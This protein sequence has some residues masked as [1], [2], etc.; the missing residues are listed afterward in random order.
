MDTIDNHHEDSYDPPSKSHIKRE[1][2]AITDLGKKI[3][4]LS[5]DRVKQLPLDEKLIEAI[6]DCQHIKT[7][8]EGKRR[9]THYVGKLLRN[10][11][12]DAIKQ[13][14]DV[15]ENGS[16]EDT[17]NMHQLETLRDRL[18]ATDDEL[19]LLLR[20]YPNTD[21]QQLRAL[22]RSARKEQ[23]NNATLSPERPPQRKSYRA[24]FQFLKSFI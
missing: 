18:I 20:E 4:Q 3:I 1:L 11:D 21:I 6:R 24:L 17:A 12:I 19:T 9:Q 22:I 10:A 14:L 5:F 7:R 13:Q 8:G 16:K 23:Q 15:W 2:L